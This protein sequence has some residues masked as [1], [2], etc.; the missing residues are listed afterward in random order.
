VRVQRVL[1]SG[2]E[3]FPHNGVVA[4]TDATRL[5]TE[6][7]AAF[8]AASG[9]V[10]VFWRETNQR[11]SQFG[12]F[13]QRVDASGTRRWTDEGR[14]LVP[15]G[16]QNVTEVRALLMPG[17]ALV[18]WAQV[19]AFDDQPIRAA[20]LDSAGAFVWPGQVVI[21]KSANTGTAR[22][23]AASSTLG[24]AMFVWTD[25]ETPRDLHAQN[26]NPDGRLGPSI[27]G[28]GFGG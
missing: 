9:D 5:R 3:A 23:A 19:E 11:Q 26:L 15:L 14:E 4:S 18:A 10:Y 20:R 16:A 7:G 21:I 8:D 12:L 27:F 6:P 17:G 1:G 13:G 22:L 2:V 25:G 28:D 24:F